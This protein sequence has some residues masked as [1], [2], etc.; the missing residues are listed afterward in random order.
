MARPLRIEFP[1]A[2]YHVTS[3]G[4]ERKAI[5]RDGDDRTM[6]LDTLARVNRRFHWL[7][8]AYCLMDNHYHLVIETPEGNLSKG[9]RQLNAV[10]TQGQNRRWHRVG[11]LLQGRYKAIV[12]EKESYLLEVSRYVVLNPVRAGMV[13]RPE[14][15][16]WSSFRATA[17]RCRPHACLMGDW[18]LAQFGARRARAQA[19]YVEFVAEGIGAGSIWSELKGQSLLGEGGFVDRLRP[20][21]H[22]HEPIREIPKVQRYANRPGL[23]ELLSAKEMGARNRRI[24]EAVEKY[25]YS[26]KEVAD[27]LGMHYSTISRIASTEIR[28]SR[29]KI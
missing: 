12:V 17:G 18:L 21:L 11:H 1:G 10:Y 19:R 2:V 4:N 3:R 29:F 5:F 14:Q 9:M 20:Y 13:K 27:H 7:C 16:I 26:Q 8:H 25:G 24:V 15:W 28:T 22:A 23:A 6:F